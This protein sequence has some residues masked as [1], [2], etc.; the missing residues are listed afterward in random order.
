[1]LSFLEKPDERE[2]GSSQENGLLSPSFAEVTEGRPTL[3]SRA[4]E[5][6]KRAIR[7]Q[8]RRERR[9][10]AC[11]QV[12]EAG[13]AVRA[14]LG[15]FAPFVDAVSVLAYHPAENEIPKWLPGVCRSEV[16]SL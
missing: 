1:V 10:L 13:A 4:G 12:E 2:S 9:C 7:Q 16:T 6:E 15:R 8:L 5:R 11:N 3:S 14:H